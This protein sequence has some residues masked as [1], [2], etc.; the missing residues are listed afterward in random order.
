MVNIKSN[1][2]CEHLNKKVLL[3]AMDVVGTPYLDAINTSLICG[4]I[5]D[6]WKQSLVI[7][8]PKVAGTAKCEEFRPI[9]M[10][11]TYE[12][13][14]EGVEGGEKQLNQYTADNNIII[15][16]QF[17]FRKNYS[18]EMAINSILLDWKLDNGNV[19]IATFLDLKRAFETV[20]RKRLPRKL[21]KYGIKGIELL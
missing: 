2:D 10:L 11:P 19:V 15:G 8:T 1:R 3:D 20:D 5:S 7:P 21:R 16:E 17:G 6:S 9:N 18:C 14:L 12:K 13:V 4:S